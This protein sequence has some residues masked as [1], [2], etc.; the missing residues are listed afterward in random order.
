[1]T[2]MLIWFNP[3]PLSRGVK[4]SSCQ[5]PHLKLYAAVPYEI[6]SDKSNQ[7]RSI[8]EAIANLNDWKAK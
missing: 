3:V 8:D 2:L 7:S 4:I 5:Q 6:L 1:M